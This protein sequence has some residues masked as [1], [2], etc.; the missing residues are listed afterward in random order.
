MNEITKSIL[1]IFSYLTVGYLGRVLG[2]IGDE[3]IK[4]FSK[5]ILNILFPLLVFHSICAH[6]ESSEIKAL[7]YLPVLGLLMV[8]V[9]A[10]IGYISSKPIK[11]S[12]IKKTFIHFCA[13]N[14]YGFLPVIILKNGW[15]EKALGFLFLL[16]LGIQTAHWT[17]GIGILIGSSPKKLIKNLFSP[18]LVTIVVSLIITLN[19]LND[20]IPR[21]LYP[22]IANLGNISVP[23]ILIVIGGSMEL[24]S[25]G[26][27]ILP[28]SY[29]SLMRLI[30]LPLIFIFILKY[31]PMS[32][33]AYEISFLVALMPVAASS[34]LLVR[35]YGGNAHFASGALFIT[36]L[37]SL[38]TIPIG[39]NLI[40]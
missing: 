39:L 8:V 27:D 14:N 38:F 4:S 3:T 32:K 35:I 34:P 16:N 33:M 18:T 22:Y 17:L 20:S 1:E 40:R 30:L 10:L 15:S 2:Y 7:W 12:D 26:K 28:I 29:L 9:G 6:F 36:T 21:N 24:R 11:N 19:G 23:L 25:I 13:V 37:L 5:L 31:I